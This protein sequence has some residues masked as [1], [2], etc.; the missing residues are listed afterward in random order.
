[1]PVLLLDLDDTLGDPQAAFLRWAQDWCAQWAPNE[2][3]AV[4]YL[5]EH[6]ADGRR[7]RP[8]VFGLL[9]QRFAVQASVD[10]LVAEYRTAL[11]AALPPIG[12]DIK[13]RLRA[14]RGSGWKIAVVTN[15][16]ADTQAAKIERLELSSLLDACCI[17]GALG[18]RKPDPRIFQIAAE[19]CGD[20]LTGAWM[21]GDSQADIVGAHNA[22][23][24]SIWLHRG[25][26]WPRQ[27]LH[28]DHAAGK[29][30][31]AL[32]LLDAAA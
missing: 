22:G 19:Q 21:I 8:E 17:S 23:I 5:V 12:D 25:R 10:A 13:T 18:I 1:M 24:R 4:G 29:L 6:D 26:T 16:D 11:Q 32:S 2:P 7:R 31:D 14:L 15:G 3:G 30:V 9:V 27:D 20:A 28:P